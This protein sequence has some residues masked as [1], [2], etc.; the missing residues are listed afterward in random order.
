MNKSWMTGGKSAE[1]IEKLRRQIADLEERREALLQK[2]RRKVFDWASY[3]LGSPAAPKDLELLR[4]GAEGREVKEIVAVY[5]LLN[6][7]I[8]DKEALLNEK[9]DEQARYDSLG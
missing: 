6:Q 8:M 9:L 3:A 4:S 7:E 2:H 1:G 5:E